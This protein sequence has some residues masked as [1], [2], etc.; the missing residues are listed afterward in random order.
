MSDWLLQGVDP[1]EPAG[2][3]FYLHTAD[4]WFDILMVVDVLA[5]TALPAA[6]RQPARLPRGPRVPDCHAVE[7]PREATRDL[8]D[9]F[10]HGG[11]EFRERTTV[12]SSSTPTPASPGLQTPAH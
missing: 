12:G 7:A 10:R 2:H 9:Q 4:D 6:G 8:L 5:A 3:E 11:R 1:R